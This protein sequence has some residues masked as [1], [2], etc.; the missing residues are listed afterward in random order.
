MIITVD[1]PAGSGKSTVARE[2]AK[3]LSIAYLDSGATYRAVTYHA[4][5]Q[6]IDLQDEAALAAL[7]KRIDLELIP[8]ADG[9]GVLVSGRDVSRQIRAPE[10]TTQ[11]RY[12]ASAPRVRA[13]LVKLQRKIGNRMGSFVSEGRDQ[14][15]VVFPDADVKF[16]LDA[17]PQVRARRR[18]DELRATGR[19]ADRR[20]ILQAIMDRDRRDRSREVGPLVKPDGAVMID[21]SEMTVAQVTEA[22]VQVIQERT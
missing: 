20:K 9:V 13:V 7:A 6:G 4:I 21:T 14:G 10:I 8:Q 5:S 15:S 19:P 17:S 2:L 1:G 22:M 18:S 16:Y 11:T 12:A 3:A